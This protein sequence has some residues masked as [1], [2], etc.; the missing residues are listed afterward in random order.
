MDPK[1]E[2]NVSCM[3]DSNVIYL[4]LDAA[5]TQRWKERD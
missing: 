1:F 3:L 5:L 4:E 2:P